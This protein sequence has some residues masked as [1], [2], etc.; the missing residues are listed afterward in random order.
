MPIPL[1]Q[2]KTTHRTTVLEL[3]LQEQDY[4][5]LKNKILMLTK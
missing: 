1:V 5:I 2:R 3:Q 4:N